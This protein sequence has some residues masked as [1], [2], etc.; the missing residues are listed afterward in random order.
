MP[1]FI[2]TLFKDHFFRVL[3]GYYLVL[4]V[5]WAWNNLNELTD[6]LSSYI[7]GGLYPLLAVAGGIGGFIY[8]RKYGGWKSALGRGV[9][10]VSL[11]LLA[12]AIGQFIWTYYNLILEVD[13]PYPSVADLFYEALPFL[14]IAGMFYF[15]RAAGAQFSLRSAKNWPIAILIPLGLLIG[16]YFFFLQGYELNW[17]NPLTV[18]LDFGIQLGEAL[19]LSAAILTFLLSRKYLGGI[20]RDKIWFV[21]V[22]F[23]IQY[24]TDFSFLYMNS[25]GLYVNG[26][27]VDFFY[28]TSFLFMSSALIFI[29]KYQVERVRVEAQAQ[30]VT[31]TWRRRDKVATLIVK[32]QVSIIGPLAW[33]EAS[34]V[35]GLSVD[36]ETGEIYL[37][38][39]KPQEILERLVERY[40]RVFGQTARE[41]SR[42][43]VRRFASEL[44]DTEIPASLR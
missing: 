20:M 12:Q 14:N 15:A 36:R 8:S 16:S 32:E 9:I 1:H 30:D 44:S 4:S 39:D 33:E 38:E 2:S 6:T 17:D 18:I 43:A 19:I 22:A 11:G 23:L 28:M 13:I 34:Q 35:A 40:E 10:F 27:V 24:L 37:L 29:A 25:Q 21:S 26:G 7:F 3:F 5:F 41:V 42:D 31:G